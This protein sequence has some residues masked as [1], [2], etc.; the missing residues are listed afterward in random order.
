MLE[1]EATTGSEL[2]LSESSCHVKIFVN[3]WKIGR[4][5]LA[6][7]AKS[8]SCQTRMSAPKVKE[9]VSPEWQCQ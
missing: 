7:L 4:I 3:D 8:S 6:M 1:D 9:V 5:D 2:V